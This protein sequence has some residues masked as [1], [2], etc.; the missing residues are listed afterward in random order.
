[1][2]LGESTPSPAASACAGRAFTK[3]PGLLPLLG[4]LLLA[5][6][7]TFASAQPAHSSAPSRGRAFARA[8]CAGCH[9]TGLYGTSPNPNSPPFGAIANREGVTRETLTSWL[10]SAH[11][12][13]MEMNFL[14]HDRDVDGLVAYFLS[15]RVRHY[16]RPADL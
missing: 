5:A 1:V 8:T 11:N 3:W 13:P 14:L 6:G 10:R 12:Y 16:R 7:Q 15:L 9:E 4:L 2:D